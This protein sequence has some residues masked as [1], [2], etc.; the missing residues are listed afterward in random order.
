MNALAQ[1]LQSH[2]LAPVVAP[3]RRRPV[4]RLVA[5][6]LLGLTGAAGV[7]IAGRPVDLKR[8]QAALAAAGYLAPAL[9]ERGMAQLSPADEC[10]LDRA[11][12]RFQADQGIAVT[13]M[14]RPGCATEQ[15]LGR[16]ARP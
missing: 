7:G 13:G 4:V 15:A 9:A 1:P 6:R 8:V 11:L 12:R 14:V 3:P 10:Q 5:V 2:D 16:F